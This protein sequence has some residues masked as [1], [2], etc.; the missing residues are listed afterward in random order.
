MKV[1][2]NERLNPAIH[3]PIQSGPVVMG[4]TWQQV[5]A[6]LCWT[7]R[8]R[9][10]WATFAPCS[11][12]PGNSRRESLIG[13]SHPTTTR[14]SAEIS[15]TMSLSSFTNLKDL[16]RID[17]ELQCGWTPPKQTMLPRRTRHTEVLVSQQ[18]SDVSRHPD[19]NRHLVHTC[20]YQFLVQ[21]DIH[22]PPAARSKIPGSG[23]TT[24]SAKHTLCEQRSL[25]T[26]CLLLPCQNFQ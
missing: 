11:E 22:V 5:P 20:C 6:T 2:R 15:S 12:K 25:C 23:A 10:L 21:H 26:P 19:H 4:C 3:N 14:Q 13:C 24:V 7:T 16:V 8:G 1:S 17:S 18:C 9:D